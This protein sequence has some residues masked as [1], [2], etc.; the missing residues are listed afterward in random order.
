MTQDSTDR[1]A[2][3][4][5]R[6]P[7]LDVEFD[8]Y[9]DEFAETMKIASEKR[10]KAKAANRKEHAQITAQIAKIDALLNETTVVLS[11]AVASGKRKE[12]P[13]AP[14]KPDWKPNDDSLAF[15]VDNDLDPERTVAEYIADMTAKDA[16]MARWGNKTF[17]AWVTARKAA[18]DGAHTPEAA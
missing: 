3:M 18:N 13:P 6:L 12:S 14:I 15:L 11:G 9:E 16:K 2:T 10:D 8:A 5:A 7:E 1:L 17:V 4:K